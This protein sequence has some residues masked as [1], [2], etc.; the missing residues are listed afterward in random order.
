MAADDVTTDRREEAAV[1]DGK[2]AGEW[3][4]RV[5]NKGNERKTEECGRDRTTWNEE[6][7]A[8]NHTR[9]REREICE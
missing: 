6:E 1:R 4:T 7:E 3:R 2:T 8:V 5:R 9:E